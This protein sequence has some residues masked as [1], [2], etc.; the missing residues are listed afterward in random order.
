[1]SAIH[2]VAGTRA[3]ARVLS[4]DPLR[5][6]PCSIVHVLSPGASGGLETVVHALAR[7]HA[8]AGHTVRVVTVSDDDAASRFLER[9][10]G[11]DVHTSSLKARGRHYALER[12]SARSLFRQ[13]RPDVVHTH[14]NR[15]DVVDAAAARSVGIATATTVHGYT[16]STLLN[17]VYGYVQRLHMRSFDAVVAVSTPLATALSSHVHPSRLHV[18]P[19]GFIPEAEPVDRLLARRRLGVN[20]D[21]F[22]IGWVGR[23][24]PEK[25]PDV[26]LAAISRLALFARQEAL[27][28][29]VIGDGPERTNLQR[30]ALQLGIE[31]LVRWHSTR[32]DAALLMKAFDVLVLSSRTE[33]TPMVI[34]EAMSARTPI[35]AT[36]V[37]GV[38]EMLS[39]EEALLVPRDDPEALASAILDVMLA[40]ADAFTRAFRAGNVLSTRYD[41]AAWLERYAVL[42]RQLRLS[43]QWRQR[44]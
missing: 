26:A 2:D 10:A 41:G 9:F 30:L 24:S 28:L 43:T 19:N 13:L 16:G 21:R 38:P 36:R 18:I 37:G 7:G 23:L 12:A 32:D 4:F 11:T 44:C 29:A 20:D 42:Y 5:D 35:I 40:R 6:Q 31:P 27:E 17:R 15:S 34:L 8:D 39:S 3:G 1:M 14:G 33:G 22:L 25:G